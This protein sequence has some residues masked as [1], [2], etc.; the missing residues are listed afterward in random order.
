M[1]HQRAW[2]CGK[3]NKNCSFCACWP[4]FAS[5]IPIDCHRHTYTHTRTFRHT[6]NCRA[7]D[8]L[9]TRFPQVHALQSLNRHL[10]QWEES[11]YFY[12]LKRNGTGVVPPSHICEK[13]PWRR[14][15]HVFVIVLSPWCWET[16]RF[17]YIFLQTFYQPPLTAA[18]SDRSDGFLKDWVP[19]I[20][21]EGGGLCDACDGKQ[22]AEE[23]SL[24]C[25]ARPKASRR[26]RG[27]IY[28]IYV[29]KPSLSLWKFHEEKQ[30]PSL[31][32]VRELNC[33]LVVQ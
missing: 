1:H 25:F 11:G 23:L 21:S 13:K 30:F 19:C 15:V 9:L 20:C 33:S 26:L 5:I 32:T 14:Q 31:L 8:L 18:L 2:S 6:S 29:E 22:P 12:T 7:F 17:E 27:N 16:S 28:I 3:L 10:W 24:V 4:R